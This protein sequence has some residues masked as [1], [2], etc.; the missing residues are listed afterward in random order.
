MGLYLDYFSNNTAEPPNPL[1]KSMSET[2]NKMFNQ[3]EGRVLPWEQGTDPHMR[4][5]Q[6]NLF[7]KDSPRSHTSFLDLSLIHI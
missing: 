6:D 7:T 4:S 3:E 1:M 2:V 5:F